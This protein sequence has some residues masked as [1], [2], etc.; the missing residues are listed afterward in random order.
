MALTSQ[1]LYALAETFFYRR[2][3]FRLDYLDLFAL[4]E[5]FQRLLNNQKVY[6]NV[7]DVDFIPPTYHEYDTHAYNEIVGLLS[8]FIAKACRLKRSMYVCPRY[9]ILRRTSDTLSL[10]RWGSGVVITKTMLDNIATFC[11]QCELH[12]QIRGTLN[13][14]VMLNQMRH[15]PCLTSLAVTLSDLHFRAFAELQVMASSCPNLKKLSIIIMRYTYES[16]AGP[17]QWQD[18]AEKSLALHTLE[19]DG[20]C[21]NIAG[22]SPLALMTD[23]STL[24]YLSIVNVSSVPDLDCDNLTSLRIA[25]N[26]NRNDASA[27]FQVARMTNFLYRCEYLEELDLTGFT[28]SI[29]PPLLGHLGKSLKV[30]RLHEYECET[31]LQ[32]RSVLSPEMISTIG[33][34]CVNLDTLGIDIAYKDQW[35][36]PTG[37]VYFSKMPLTSFNVAISCFRMLNTIVVVSS[38]A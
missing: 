33:A 11:P 4:Q 22:G 17:L 25:L 37:Q 15:N 16:E 7:Q 3:K 19:L 14:S 21:P 8:I 27:E 18:H 1:N 31:G 6:T 12:T 2:L 38:Q 26:G 10:N 5:L 13:T 34:R 24:R 36:S 30:L 20:F 32:R 29:S 23:V 28:T 9:D 35:V